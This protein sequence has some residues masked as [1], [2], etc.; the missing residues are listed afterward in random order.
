MKHRH[1]SEKLLLEE[2]SKQAAEAKR[3]SR[4]LP[5]GAFIRL[6]RKQLGMSQSL[7]ARRAKVPQSTVSR[8]EKG[9]KEAKLSTL[10]KIFD[11]LSCDLVL[12]PLLRDSIRSIRHCQAEKVA[13]KHVRYLKGTMS[14]EK[15]EPDEQ[16]LEELRNQET[17]KLLHGPDFRLW[18]E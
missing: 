16:F 2:V 3:V 6:I 11:A 13:K 8:V 4:N 18:E 7:L 12:I 9:E 15:Q 1:F 5:V 17:E 10:L 14:L